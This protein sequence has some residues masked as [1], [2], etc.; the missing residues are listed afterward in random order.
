MQGKQTFR[1]FN[2]LF[3]VAGSGIVPTLA[4][5]RYSC[6]EILSINI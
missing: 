1:E 6:H 2:A 5:N 4:T 3:G